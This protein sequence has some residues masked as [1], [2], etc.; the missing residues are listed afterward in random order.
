MSFLLVFPL[1][2]SKIPSGTALINE[3]CS[4]WQRLLSNFI[5]LI[6]KKKKHQCEQ[7][8]KAKEYEEENAT[9]KDLFRQWYKKK[10]KSHKVKKKPIK[11]TILE[12]TS[13]SIK[14]REWMQ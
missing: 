3:R 9:I 1:C 14:I 6:Q 12:S 8:F 10:K 11:N 2:V 7:W 4:W 5:E 13:R